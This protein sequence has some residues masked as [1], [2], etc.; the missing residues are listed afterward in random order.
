MNNQDSFYMNLALQLAWLKKGTTSP[1]P[2]VGAV[3]VKNNQILSTGI[4]QPPGGFH[5][6]REA[7]NKLSLKESEGASLF[8]TL[9]PCSHFGKTPPCTE[10]IIEKKIKRV[11]I[12]VLDPN[13]LVSGKGLEILKKAGIEVEV[14]LLGKK[15]K[16]INEDFFHWI[17]KER[18]LVTLKYA[19][20]LDGKMALENGNSKWITNERSRK[21]THILR[22]RSDAIMVGFN[23]VRMDNPLLNA[24]LYQREKNLLRVIIDPEGKTP[25][26]SQIAS[27]SLPSLFVV[28]KQQVSGSFVQFISNTPEKEIYYDYEEG[29]EIN[30][31]NLLN[32]LGKEKKITSLFV[33]GGSGVL[34]SFLKQG[35][36]NRVFVFLANRIV[37]QGLSP[38]SGFHVNEVKEGIEIDDIKIK[39][40]K[41]N[42]LIYGNLNWKT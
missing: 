9:E 15:A 31:M 22:Y 10:I 28:K 24:R 2:T 16:E 8:V 25:I 33:E 26:E 42:I 40:L 3:V 13:P 38:F 7:L 32:Y 5:A 17:Q 12:A 14:G 6:E 39:K 4:T 41:N 36:G 19:S 27:D 21:I 23:T 37:G 18:P 35:I 29:F 20:T 11:V 34:G 30:L 1:N